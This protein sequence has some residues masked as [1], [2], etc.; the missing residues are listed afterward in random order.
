MVDE[1]QD[2]G[3]VADLL[4]AVSVAVASPTASKLGSVARAAEGRPATWSVSSASGALTHRVPRRRT[5]NQLSLLTRRCARYS[6]QTRT[7]LRRLFRRPVGGAI[8]LGSQCR[9]YTKSPPRWLTGM[10]NGGRD[11]AIWSE[12]PN[13]SPG[14]EAGARRSRLR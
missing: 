9:L 3:A 7:G 12:M 8:T 10:E 11:Q 13:V 6:L 5:L 4:E 2:A 1:A 14:L